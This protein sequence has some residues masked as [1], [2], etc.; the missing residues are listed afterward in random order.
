MPKAKGRN[1]D[2][3]QATRSAILA[4]AKSLFEAH[5]FDAV[6]AQ[7]IAEAAGVSHGAVFDHFGSKRA[8]FIAVHDAWQD[9]LVARIAEAVAGDGEPWARFSAIW[10]AYLSSTEDPAMRQIL[11]L[12]GPRVIGLA[13]MRARDRESAFAF[14]HEEVAS[15]IRAGLIQPMDS[16]GLAILLF[17]ALDQAAFELADFPEDATLRTRLLTSMEAVMAALRTKPPAP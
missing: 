3:R 6:S 15:L 5:G 11:L 16:H 12:D 1:A 14:F 10:R 17:G 7:A 13:E 2:M 9:A 4:A 8:L